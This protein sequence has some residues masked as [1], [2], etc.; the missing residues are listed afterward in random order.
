MLDEHATVT[1][2]SKLPPED[3]CA[4]LAALKSYAIIDTEPEEA[5]DRI[6]RIISSAL[7]TPI[8]FVTFV[9]S[10]RIWFKS[11]HGAAISECNREGAFCTVTIAQNARLIVED[12]AR[13]PRFADNP[14]VIGPYG[15]RFY[16]GTPLRTREGVN[17]GTLCALDTR[18]RTLNEQQLDIL[19]D[20]ASLVVDEL[21]LRRATKIALNENEK[22][23][24][25]FASTTSDWFWEMD[26]NLR[27]SYFSERFT[28]ITGV[29][30]E[31][32]LGKTRQES[33]VEHSLNPTVWRDHLSDL[34]AH[35][36]FRNFVHP[37]TKADGEVVWLAISGVPHHDENG[38]FL[39]YRG[40]GADITQQKL[41]EDALRNAKDQAERA[42]KAKTEFVANMSHEL[43]TPLNAIIGF[44]TS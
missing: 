13:D 14:F 31:W 24:R 40:T 6:T 15:I 41:I 39:G 21:D 43:R 37:R 26:E 36:P 35:R 34:A 16:A 18:P 22:R 27:F 38:E 1:D 4:R 19:D 5:F 42:D 32:L 8:A 44:P 20:M 23:F 33:G 29:P 25:D 11:T 2:M 9:E 28:E 30:E 7:G 17:L 3:E 12:A 10:D